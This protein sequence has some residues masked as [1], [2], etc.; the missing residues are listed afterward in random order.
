MADQMA[1]TRWRLLCKCRASLSR[2][3]V[4]GF[5]LVWALSMPSSGEK[6]DSCVTEVY[7][8]PVETDPTVPK[9]RSICERISSFSRASVSSGVYNHIQHLCNDTWLFTVTYVQCH[10]LLWG[11]WPSWGTNHYAEKVAWTG[12][13]FMIISV[14]WYWS[15]GVWR[16]L[17]A[18]ASQYNKTEWLEFGF[19]G[20]F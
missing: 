6:K 9:V 7:K 17:Y 16:A 20:F 2:V 19:W 3:V 15:C 13:H 18:I 14:P 4:L 1:Y 5:V 11:S 12:Q 8:N 10:R